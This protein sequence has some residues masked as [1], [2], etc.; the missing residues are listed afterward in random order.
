MARI[1]A[2]CKIGFPKQEKAKNINERNLNLK[3]LSVSR[4]RKER[5]LPNVEYCLESS[6]SNGL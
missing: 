2:I 5:K 1:F 3:K 6:L 4:R